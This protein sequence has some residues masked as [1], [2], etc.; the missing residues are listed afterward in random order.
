VSRG[1]KRWLIGIAAAAGAGAIAVLITARELSKRFEPYIKE[2][3][4]QYLE[5]RFHSEVELAALRVSIPKSSP[6]KLVVERGKGVLAVVEGEGISL[7]HRGRRDVPPMF[8]M[9]RFRFEVDIGKLFE[10]PV[11]VRQVALTG[12]EITVPPKGQRP[13]LGSD[14][15]PGPNAPKTNVVI[16]DVLIDDARLT[17]LPKDKTKFP[18][19]FD[20]HRARLRSAGNATAMD[21]A[22]TL[23]NAKPPGEIQSKGTFGPWRTSRAIRPWEESTRSRT[24]IWASS[25]ESPER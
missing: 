17:I 8:A 13:E 21:Y 24:P 16:E 10:K 15:S 22:A 4:I 5:Q 12:M 14:A 20:I 25:P 23:T 11:V 18:L 7:R 1:K 6:W 3:A 9:R 19:E 2:Q